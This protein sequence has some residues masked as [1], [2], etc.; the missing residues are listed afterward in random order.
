MVRLILLGPPG[1]GKGTQA[2]KLADERAIP[3]ISTGVILREA[4]AAGTELGKRA[5]AIMDEG[6]LVPDE[7]V[8]ALVAERLDQEDARAGFILDGYPRNLTQAQVLATRP[9]GLDAVLFLDVEDEVLI[10][11]IQ[12][13][14]AQEGREARQARA[15]RGP[16]GQTQSSPPGARHTTRKP[17]PPYRRSGGASFRYAARRLWSSRHTV[18]RAAASRS[19]PRRCAPWRCA[20][21]R[22][23]ARPVRASSRHSR[24]RRQESRSP[25]A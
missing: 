4:S 5:Q 18:S 14:A 7:V 24:A 3:H 1:A 19:S 23:L 22:R 10:R 17:T 12:G 2:A 25:G 13:R 21:P 15:Q 16:E 20:A 9:D 8:D 11:R 6:K